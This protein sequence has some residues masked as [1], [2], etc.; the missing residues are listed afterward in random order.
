[1]RTS[2][3]RAWTIF[4]NQQEHQNFNCLIIFIEKINYN[5]LLL[6][7]ERIISGFENLKRNNNSLRKIELKVNR[8]QKLIQKLIKNK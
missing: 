4:V 1:M 5:T 3:K 7:K 6:L 2:N 8:R